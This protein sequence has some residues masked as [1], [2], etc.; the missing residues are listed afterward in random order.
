MLTSFERRRLKVQNLFE[1][2]H[3]VVDI[4]EFTGETKQFVKRWIERPTY[5]SK[6]KS[7][8]PEILSKEQQSTIVKWF[9]GKLFKSLRKTLAKIEIE[10]KVK[11]SRE[12]LRRY[13]HKTMSSYSRTKKPF[14]TEQHK[15]RRLQYAKENK[16][17]CFENVVFTDE[18][19]F[20]L[21]G[22][23][24]SRLN[25]IWATSRSNV[26]PIRTVQH[27]KRVNVWGAI[28][29]SKAFFYVYKGTLNSE[30][31]IQLVRKF[32]RDFKKA[33]PR[34]PIILQHDGA[35]CHA[36]KKTNAWL[37]KQ[38]KRNVH[39]IKSGRWG[40]WPAQSPDLNIIESVWSRLKNAVYVRQPTTLQELETYL[41]QEWKKLTPADLQK[42]YESISR[43]LEMVIARGGD[44]IPY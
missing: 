29:N 41:E 3:S 2:G 37:I 35:P 11:I 21:F 1:V 6:L 19:H 31:Y 4:M 36:S 32:I 12:T 38:R 18:S 28:C 43:R 34:R 5:R 24:S 27:P 8:R 42:L 15:E 9:D 14:L 25:R 23:P 10:F 22:Q 39:F 26:P 7:G 20:P 30:K 33:F 40:K 44:S 17:T 16:A 13:L